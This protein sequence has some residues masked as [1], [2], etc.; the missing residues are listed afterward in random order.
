MIT[1]YR[2]QDK[3]VQREFERILSK[4]SQIENNSTTINNTA[5]S[6]SGS[7]STGTGTTGTASSVTVNPMINIQS[8]SC[9]NPYVTDDTLIIEEGTV[10]VNILPIDSTSF[11]AEEYWK[12][13][14]SHITPDNGYGGYYVYGL[15]ELEY[16]P[17]TPNSV[18]VK[19]VDI[20][21][22]QSDET[23]QEGIP[24]VEAIKYETGYYNNGK[25]LII[26]CIYKGTE[27]N[28]FIENDITKLTTNIKFNYS[29]MYIKKEA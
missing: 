21:E 15:I 8:D 23:M 10:D 11:P 28:T 6:S 5:K 1:S 18:N 27:Y 16:E 24:E 4:I 20:H 26:H 19:L 12:Y 9:C 13:A 29:L 2:H 14:Y 22:G 25:T 17:Q 7:S 3:Y